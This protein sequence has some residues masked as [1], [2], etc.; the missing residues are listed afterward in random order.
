VAQRSIFAD[1]KVVL[2]AAA[3]SCLLWGS[4]V[5][6]VKIGYGLLGI[7]PTDFASQLLFAGVRFCLA[8]LMLLM[9]AI[10]TERSIAL[11]PRRIAQMALLG[12]G[13]TAIVYFLLY[14]GFANTTGVKASIMTATNTFFAVLI[15]HF[16]FADDRLTPRRI[17]GCLI[18]L[19][20]VIIINLT[21]A[22]FDFHFSW[23]GEGTI[24]LA[25]LI[26]S[27]AQIYGRHLSRGMDATVMT[28]W[29]LLLGGVILT[30]AGLVGHGHFA[31]FGLEAGVLI[32]Y[33]A[34]VSAVAFAL[35]GVLYKHNP[36]SLIAAF[37]F[38]I[39]VFGVLCSGLLLGEPLLQWKNLTA[40]ILVS[41]GIWLV[42][43]T[44]R[45]PAL[46]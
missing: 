38:L 42:S 19:A 43:T 23:L 27:F 22:D 37:S 28:G 20:G 11:S 25:M 32:V 31:Q 3:L 4:A 46:A 15:A 21:A 41:F 44:S 12:L 16:I 2:A 13:Q 7:S 45:K 18:G 5:P 34:A 30:A 29:Q 35:F 26:L 8:G 33:L 17:A 1:R 6:G 9:L 14:V 36:V 40:L 39:P 24:V 10:A